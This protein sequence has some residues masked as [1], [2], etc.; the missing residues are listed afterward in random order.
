MGSKADEAG[1]KASSSD[2]K[3]P[4]FFN[5]EKEL[6]SSANWVNLKLSLLAKPNCQQIL[7][8]FEIQ[9][10]VGD[11]KQIWQNNQIDARTSH[12]R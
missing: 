8:Q 7:R 1:Y 12:R 2:S 4:L 6:K 9:V 10:Q 5:V 11:A 3:R